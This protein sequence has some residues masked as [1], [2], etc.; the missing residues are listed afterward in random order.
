MGIEAKIK[1][2]AIISSRKGVNLPNI[3][4]DLPPLSDKDKEDIKFGLTQGIDM[5]FASFMRKASD[6]Q[7]IRKFMGKKGKLVKIIAKIEN[8]EGVQ[9]FD[10]ILAEADGIMVAR[11][12]LGIEIPPQKVFLAQKMMIAKCNIAGKPVIV[13]TQMLESMTYN[14][15][16]T[17]A[18]VTDV[19]NA[20]LDGADCVMLSG[21]TAKGDFPVETVQ[22]MSE[23]CLAAES[24]LDSSHF[25]QIKN[26]KRRVRVE[27]LVQ[28]EVCCS[29]VLAAVDKSIKAIITVSLTG[30]STR[31]ISKFR[32]RVPIIQLSLDLHVGYC[33]FLS[34]G[35]VP[36]YHPEKY[37]PE[38]EEYSEYID[39]ILYKA[40]QFAETNKIIEIEDKVIVLHAHK[41][42]VPTDTM[43]IITYQNC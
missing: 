34:S 12:V 20:V 36:F 4:V 5:I 27:H 13:A 14:P 7:I 18:E 21:E 3:E 23:I 17:R 15:R 24:A 9:K 38:D 30:K 8:H 35:C 41:D 43:R 37:I 2:D 42:G 28:Q 32:P 11:G 40:M 6:I 1:N 33:G 22:M 25:R 29:A 39:R 26:L 31:M 19:A 10:Q 16:P